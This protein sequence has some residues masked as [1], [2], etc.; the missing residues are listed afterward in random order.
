[1]S[2]DKDQF[3]ISHADSD[4]FLLFVSWKINILRKG[5]MGQTPG[6]TGKPGSLRSLLRWPS[7][8]LRIQQGQP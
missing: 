8:P 3:L 2:A 4:N 5:L 1:V 7:V 6:I